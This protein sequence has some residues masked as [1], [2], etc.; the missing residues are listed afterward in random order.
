MEQD[1]VAE[2]NAGL[3]PVGSPIER[4]DAAVDALRGRVGDAEDHGV[5]DTEQVA[6]HGVD[7]SLGGGRVNLPRGLSERP[8][9][10][11]SPGLSLVAPELR[12]SLLDRPG[13]SGLGRGLEE[14]PELLAQS[15]GKVPE[16]P[17]P[18]VAR[19]REV[20][21]AVLLL[22]PPR[23]GAPGL[24][25]GA[26]EEM[27]CV[28]AVEAEFSVSSGTCYPADMMYG[29][30]MSIATTSVERSC[31][32]FI[33]STKLSMAPFPGRQRRGGRGHRRGPSRC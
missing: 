5:H 17:Q 22:L 24:I 3:V 1:D 8:P 4:L 7:R 11:L 20:T 26:R 10:L 33:Y 2:S 14:L 29:M 9:R 12:G 21:V 18:Q 23:L 31:P 19:A 15:L 28:E 30:C 25:D 6:A 13:L 32:G 16:V 27:Y